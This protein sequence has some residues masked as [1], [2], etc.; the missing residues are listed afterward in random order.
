[1]ASTECPRCKGR[2]D[3]RATRCMHCQ[4]DFTAEEIGEIEQRDSK[5]F[6]VPVI[7]TIAAIAVV[8]G[9]ATNFG[10]GAPQPA[11][12]ETTTDTAALDPFAATDPVLAL[13]PVEPPPPVTA[14]GTNWSYDT[15]RDELRNADITTASVTSN[16][17]V[18]LGSPYGTIKMTMQV[19]QHP[20]YG[21]DVIFMADAG[22]IL[23]PSYNGCTGKI[24]FDGKLESLSAVGS[25]DHNSEV[26]FAQYGKAIRDKIAKSDKVIVEVPMYQAGN[27]QFVFDT[28]GFEWPKP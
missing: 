11:V 14:P 5:R 28:A 25:A 20:E 3:T 23:C 1:M 2:I 6:S 16:N 9:L 27:P 12:A 26:I 13:A 10:N 24:S 8:F 7:A 15:K 4:C 17:S 18:S 22:Q 19:R 21:L